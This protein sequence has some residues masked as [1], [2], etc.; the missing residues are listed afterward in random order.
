MGSLGEMV[1]HGGLS[2]MAIQVW[3]SNVWVKYMV[4]HG[5]YGCMVQH[6]WHGRKGVSKGYISGGIF[7]MGS[8]FGMF[9]CGWYGCNCFFFY[10][11]HT[12][13]DWSLIKYESN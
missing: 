10:G 6:V 1:C 8:V 11:N 13:V 2:A 3:Q 12:C 9:C 5:W 7:V 4:S